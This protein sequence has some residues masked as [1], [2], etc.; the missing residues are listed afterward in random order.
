MLVRVQHQVPNNFHSGYIV[1]QVD[2]LPWKQ[3]DA[4]AEP[5]TQT[6]KYFCSVRLLVRSL[7]FQG[8]ETSSILVR[9]TSNKSEYRLVRFK[10]SAL[11]A[12]N[13]EF[14]SLYSDQKINCPV[15]QLVW[16]LVLQTSEAGSK[17]ARGT[18]NKLTN[19]VTTVIVDA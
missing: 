2:G 14:E 9:S 1:S 11:G 5:A 8:G 18:S 16:Q 17:P 12:E 4:G 7:P 3:E 15:M 19:N 6:T 13:R 10:S